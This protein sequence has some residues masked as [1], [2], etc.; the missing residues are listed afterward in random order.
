MW[1]VRDVS[2]FII[3]VSLVCLFDDCDLALLRYTTYLSYASLIFLLML[4]N[5]C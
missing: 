5:K 1:D 3:Q 2:Y 4:K